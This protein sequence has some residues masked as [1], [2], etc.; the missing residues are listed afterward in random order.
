MVKT[1]YSEVHLQRLWA[2]DLQ[3]RCVAAT[4]Q[5]VEPQ[6]MCVVTYFSCKFFAEIKVTNWLYQQTWKQKL[7]IL[8]KKLKVFCILYLN[9]LLYVFCP[10]HIQHKFSSTNHKKSNTVCHSCFPVTYFCVV[11]FY[12]CVHTYVLLYERESISDI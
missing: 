7:H 1:K 10:A 9:T 12:T 2:Q 8:N 3:M 5:I 6:V 11:H 4:K